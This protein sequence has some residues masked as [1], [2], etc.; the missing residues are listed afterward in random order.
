MVE[1]AVASAGVVTG[2][3]TAAAT[4]TKK[5]VAIAQE[6]FILRE[7]YREESVA[8]I[9]YNASG[10]SEPLP[11]EAEDAAHLVFKRC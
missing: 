9:Q 8:S 4:A 3:G 11:F 1:L 7:S 5:V 6:N 10:I 2:V